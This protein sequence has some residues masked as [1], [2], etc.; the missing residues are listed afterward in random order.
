[1][2]LSTIGD[3][4]AQLLAGA[5]RA[6]RAGRP[7]RRPRRTP[8]RGAAPPCPRRARRWTSSLPSLETGALCSVARRTR[9]RSASSR[10][11]RSVSTMLLG[12]HVHVAPRAARRAERAWSSSPCSRTSSISAFGRV[13]L[14]RLHVVVAREPL[15]VELARVIEHPPRERH[16]PPGELESRGRA[17]RPADRAPGARRGRPRAGSRS[18]RARCRGAASAPR[19]AISRVARLA[20]AI[21]GELGADAE[22]RLALLRRSRPRPP[23]PP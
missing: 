15:G 3:L 13:E 16:R 12:A 19:T 21:A 23:R 8:G 1:M 2:P 22:E 17:R 11:P 5:D 10:S 7:R 6:R 4:G 18:G 14:L 20:G 9:A